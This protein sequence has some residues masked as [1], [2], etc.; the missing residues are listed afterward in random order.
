MVAFRMAPA[1][2][3]NSALKLLVWILNSW[4]ASTGGR[5]TKSV[6]GSLADHLPNRG[7][8]CLERRRFGVYHHRLRR[9][10]GRQC[11]IDNHSL[12]YGYRDVILLDPL[13]TF[14]FR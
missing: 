10:A 14:D 8:L 3:P 13:E 7:I 4:I 11:E 9:L 5:T 12:L 1:E 2:R 6:D